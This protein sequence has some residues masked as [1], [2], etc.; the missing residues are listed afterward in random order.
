MTKIKS[1]DK[2]KLHYNAKFEDGQLYQSTENR[3]P[4][5]FDLGE[6]QVIEG[7]RKNLIGMEV[8]E[9]KS[10]TVTPEEAFGEHDNNLI[11]DVDRGQFPDNMTPFIGQQLRMEREG[12]DEVTVVVTGL[13]DNT[14]TIDANHP[15]AGKTLE[16]DVEIVEI[17]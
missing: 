10:F 11:A 2:V 4:E 16:F 7:I 9:K 8:G 13:T 14:V 12:G 17:D 3:D 6:G 1:G 15:L 5:Q